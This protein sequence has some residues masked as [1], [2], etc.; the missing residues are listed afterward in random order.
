MTRRISSSRPITGSSLP[1]SAASV[2]SRPKRSSAWYLS[3]GLWSVTRCAAAHLGAAPEQ[4]R[5]P[6][7]RRRAARAGGLA[8]RAGER[9]QQVLGRD[10]LVLAVPPPRPR[11]RVKTRTS[12]PE[13]RASPA[14]APDTDGSL[15]R[16]AFSSARMDSAR[17]PIL[18]RIGATMPP[19]CSIST[20]SRCSGVISGLERSWASRC[21]AWTASCDLIVNLSALIGFSRLLSV[22]F[23]GLG[24]V[25]PR[26]RVSSRRTI[27]PGG[28]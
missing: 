28:L 2:R 15:S 21:A 8:L 16:A 11:P 20:T 26:W 13:G 3:S 17:A 23:S 22:K 5:R 12:S 25:K 6:A 10:V 9:Q 7:P 1:C 27:A 19:S 24:C 14:A 4:R 18:A